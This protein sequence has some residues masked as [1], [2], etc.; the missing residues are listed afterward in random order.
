MICGI[1]W[2]YFN[3]FHSPRFSCKGH[4]NFFFS[5]N[6]FACTALATTFQVFYLP[7]RITGGSILILWLNNLIAFYPHCRDKIDMATRLFDA[8][9]VESQSLRFIIQ[10]ATNSLAAAYMVYKLYFTYISELIM[11]NHLFWFAWFWRPIHVY[12]FPNWYKANAVG[13]E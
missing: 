1:L 6:R 9:K 10:E 12:L 3:L 4:Q 5:S 2:N 7:I 8:L 13:M 11:D